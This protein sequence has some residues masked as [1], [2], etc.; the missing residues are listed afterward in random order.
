M[1]FQ[2]E[3]GISDIFIERLAKL[4]RKGDIE[5]ER[6][7]YMTEWKSRDE[8]ISESTSTG[9]KS[10]EYCTCWGCTIFQAV[11]CFSA[12]RCSRMFHTKKEVPTWNGAVEGCDTLGFPIFTV[13]F[14]Q[15]S[16]F[17]LFWG[18]KKIL[19]PFAGPLHLYWSRM[20]QHFPRKTSPGCWPRAATC[21]AIIFT[22][23]SCYGHGSSLQGTESADSWDYPPANMAEKYMRKLIIHV[24][25]NL[26]FMLYI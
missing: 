13:S 4:P 5:T 2:D 25:Y 18:C 23:V 3:C 24:I 6:D 26:S 11:Y 16:I 21:Q 19:A 22:S 9:L 8:H 17:S 20:V 15:V 10:T 14:F 7:E 1:I 12:A